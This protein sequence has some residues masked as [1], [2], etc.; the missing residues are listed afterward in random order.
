MQDRIPDIL[1]AED[2]PAD[3]FLVKEAIRT[4]ALSVNLHV[5][6]DGEAAIRVI[7]AIEHGEREVYPG[8]ILLDLN[9]PRRTGLE[10]LARLRESIQC[11]GIPVA[12]ISSSRQP[13]EL[14][15]EAGVHAD[16]FFT[17]PSD[18]DRFMELGGIIRD[19][20]HSPVCA[21]A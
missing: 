18:Y 7:E 15:S 12:I 5:V 10:V 13:A 21:M 1:L 8:V 6:R 4:Y 2:N 3:V 16:R 19:L 17:K 9:L 14:A 11:G 20:L